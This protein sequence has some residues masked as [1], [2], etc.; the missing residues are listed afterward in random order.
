LKTTYIRDGHG[1]LIGTKTSGFSNGD[2]IARDE[3][4]QLVGH[5]SEMF[6]NTRDAQ[7]R[8]VSRNEADVNLLF[9]R[10]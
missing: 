9:R 5:S 3:H 2:V 6:R 10:K 8:L 4:G 1:Q 7:G